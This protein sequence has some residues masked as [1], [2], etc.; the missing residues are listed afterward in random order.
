MSREY[1]LKIAELKKQIEELE[2][3][4]HAETK[5][6]EGITAF[7]EAISE[8]TEKYGISEYELL[9]SRQEVIFNWL[10]DMGKQASPAH[11][12]DKLNDL[13]SKHTAKVGKLRKI[14]NT[15]A[16]DKEPKKTAGS[17]LPTGR[18]K[19]PHTGE[20]IE[21]IKRAPKQLE[22]WLEEHGEDIVAAW[23]Y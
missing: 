6:L 9:L 22:H 17:K 13:F 4:K 12:F 11:I 5:K 10:K 8:I 15:K 19:N 21:K 7:N 14:S 1:D 20:V 16:G 3:Q 23:R 18:Y 2:I